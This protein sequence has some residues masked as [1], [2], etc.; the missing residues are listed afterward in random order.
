MVIRR[1]K[2]PAVRLALA[3][4]V[5]GITVAACGD[6]ASA[7]TTRLFYY[8]Q[9]AGASQAVLMAID[10][11][12]SDFEASRVEL[13]LGAGLASLRSRCATRVR[14]GQWRDGAVVDAEPRWLVISGADGALYRVSASSGDMPSARRIGREPAGAP[15][16]QCVAVPDYRN[17]A[18]SI[19]AYA[20]PQGARYSQL[21]PAAEKTAR[22]LNGR[23]FFFFRSA[24]SGAITGYLFTRA[25]DLRAGYL[26][27]RPVKRLRQ[28]VTGY[29]AWGPIGGRYV[30]I[31]GSE[32][33]GFTPGNEAG[34]RVTSL[35]VDDGLADRAAAEFYPGDPALP[36]DDGYL[37]SARGA[38]GA[39]L[40]QVD[41]E[42]TPQVSRLT[43]SNGRDLRLLA[44]AGNR[45][46]MQAPGAREGGPREGELL[47]LGAESD[48]LTTLGTT[49][50]LLPSRRPTLAASSEWAV[51]AAANRRPMAARLDGETRVEL[52][53]DDSRVV[54]RLGRRH[55]GTA[56]DGRAATR[57]LYRDGGNLYSVDAA[58][59]NT[60]EARIELGSL[61]GLKEDKYRR[62]YWQ[63]SRDS[64]LLFLERGSGVM[65]V[66][67]VNP[68]RGGSLAVIDQDGDRDVRP[69]G[70]YKLLA[71]R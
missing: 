29:E 56:A 42:A 22:P 20:G 11:S 8:S 43:A 33:L 21:D 25:G 67:Y 61:P 3:T 44:T 6:G 9:P 18:D 34:R 62:L 27:E 30:V 68:S 37:L 69:V 39:T 26:D 45:I 57:L 55:A 46:L 49:A 24:D 23:G 19:I 10:A 2:G 50:A 16:R 4:I 15:I 71:D 64:A 58:S 66:A 1:P 59:P 28:G 41:T 60:E 36:F 17:A 47:A 52:G 31:A 54:R 40:V 32:W 35:T 38:S 53:G 48:G 51:F 5:V 13:S 12:S 14:S 63:G 7:D 70:G 65:D